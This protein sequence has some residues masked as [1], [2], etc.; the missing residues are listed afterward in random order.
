M[1][2][3]DGAELETPTAEGDADNGVTLASRCGVA[4]GFRFPA[5]G[6]RWWRLPDRTV[7]VQDGVRGRATARPTS[8]A[9]R[10]RARSTRRIQHSRQP[11]VS[12]CRLA[13]FLEPVGEREHGSVAVGAHLDPQSIHAP[14]QLHHPTADRTRPSRPRNHCP[15]S[16]MNRTA[17]RVVAFADHLVGEPAW[18]M[19]WARSPPAT[20]S[21]WVGAGV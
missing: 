11:A 16:V 14:Q 6:D 20:P 10:R 3:R 4:V 5:R 2:F 7:D 13:Q 19:R 15:V 18:R 1:V 12:R 9:C 17:H 21:G 8:T